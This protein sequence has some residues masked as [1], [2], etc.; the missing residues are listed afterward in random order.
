MHTSAC[1]RACVCV[2]VRARARARPVQTQRCAHNGVTLQEA[3]KKKK[4]KRLIF[5]RAR[6]VT[7]SQR[8]DGLQETPTPKKRAERHPE[9]A[10]AEISKGVVSR[11]RE[12]FRFRVLCSETYHAH[13][14]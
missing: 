7:H 2:S 11:Y 10:R 13:H 8:A 3:K 5:Q 12:F 6:T 14:L 4:K 9:D 1:A